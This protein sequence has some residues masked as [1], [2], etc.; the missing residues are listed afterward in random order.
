MYA[1]AGKFE[2]D[3]AIRYGT[4]TNTSLLFKTS[5]TVAEYPNDGLSIIF[6]S[7]DD[8]QFE[9]SAIFNLYKVPA[10]QFLISVP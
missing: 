5:F 3:D 2:T 4:S 1:V 8:V 7:T 6:S 10:V 9:L